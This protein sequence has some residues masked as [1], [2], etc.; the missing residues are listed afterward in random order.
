MNPQVSPFRTASAFQSGPRLCPGTPPATAQW[1]L[2]VERVACA[3]QPWNAT[4]AVLNSR[5]DKR[6]SDFTNTTKRINQMHFPWCTA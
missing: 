4:A 3:L 1:M 6:A 2:H 5:W